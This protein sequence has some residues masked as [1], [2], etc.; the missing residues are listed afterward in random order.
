MLLANKWCKRNWLAQIQL[1]RTNGKSMRHNYATSGLSDFYC[2]YY[3]VFEHV[4]S[5]GWYRTVTAGLLST[6]ISNGFTAT[7]TL[8]DLNWNILINHK[9]HMVNELELCTLAFRFKTVMHRCGIA[10]TSDQRASWLVLFPFLIDWCNQ[11]IRSFVQFSIKPLSFFYNFISI[12]LPC[13]ETIWTEFLL[14]IKDKVHP[15][16]GSSTV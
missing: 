11:V 12:L 14:V 4:S 5:K 6:G 1:T 9:V 16:I 2:L 13:I 3:A 15:L 8:T 10:K 7:Q